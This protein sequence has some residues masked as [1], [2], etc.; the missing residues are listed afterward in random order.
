MVRAGP[1][2]AAVSGVQVF[3]AD[4]Y[5]YRH[6]RG[7]SLGRGSASDVIAGRRGPARTAMIFVV[8]MRRIALRGLPRHRRAEG[9]A[10]AEI[11]SWLGSQY[12]SAG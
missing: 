4:R 3:A 12:R 5:R 11:G 10:R 2:D 7:L 1:G 8:A 6:L 9:A